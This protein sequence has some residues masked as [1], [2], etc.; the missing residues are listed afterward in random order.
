MALPA[1]VTAPPSVPATAPAAPSVP[2]FNSTPS[3]PS[4]FPAAP[5]V[6]TVPAAPSLPAVP[7]TKPSTLQSPGTFAPGSTTQPPETY[8]PGSKSPAIVAT[9]PLTNL[10]PGVLPARTSPA[11]TIEAVCPETVAFGQEFTYKLIVRNTGTAAVSGLRVDDELPAG[12]KYVGSDP[13][14]RSTA[15]A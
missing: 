3:A 13:V 8:A 10:A 11:V 9:P 2:A 5:S 12:S 1:P 6:P 14:A 7:P 4:V 15:T